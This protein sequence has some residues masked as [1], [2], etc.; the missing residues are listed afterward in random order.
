MA[1]A[2]MAVTPIMQDMVMVAMAT[3]PLWSK[4]RQRRRYISNKPRLWRSKTLQAT[5][6]TAATQRAITL[7]SNSAQAVGSKFR[8]RLPT[9][10]KEYGHVLFFKIIS[11]RNYI[12]YYW[13]CKLTQWPQCHGTTGHRHVF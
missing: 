10:L 8:Q 7:I 9:T 6:I 2:I 4:C 12:G 3:H 13:M 1:W 5:G 11:G